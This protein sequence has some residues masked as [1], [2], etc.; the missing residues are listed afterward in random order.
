[1]LRY[2]GRRLLEMIPILL[3]VAVLI[4]LMMEFVPGDPVKIILG[5][6]ATPAQ[7]EEVREKMGFNEPF[8]VRFF[9][10]S[11]DLPMMC[12]SRPMT[13]ALAPTINGSGPRT[14]L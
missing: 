2:I 6:T 13:W 12:S 5:D 14:T 8:F 10:K 11:I 7:I 9:S 3:V 1:M 4:F